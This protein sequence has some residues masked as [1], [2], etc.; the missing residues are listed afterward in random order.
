[1][2]RIEV[3]EMVENRSK[4]QWWWTQSLLS[5]NLES[6]NL[7]N[8]E[9][10]WSMLIQQKYEKTN[11]I[12]ILRHQYLFFKFFIEPIDY[13][14]VSIVRINNTLRRSSLILLEFRAIF[15]HRST[16]NYMR[17][18]ATRKPPKKIYLKKIMHESSSFID[19]NKQGR[20]VAWF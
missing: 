3:L 18:F 14:I 12:W 9:T 19:W 13:V 5:R 11:I 16:V 8:R 17:H 7:Y 4:H 1:M 6:S 15:K 20:H 2:L 10:T